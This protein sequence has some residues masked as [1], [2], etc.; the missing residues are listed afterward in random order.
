MLNF[1]IT[2]KNVNPQALEICKVLS[3]EGYQSFLVGGCVRDLLLGINPKDWDIC[4][5]ALPAKIMEIF[6]KNYPTGLKHGTITVVMGKDHFE[7]TTFRIEGEYKDGRRPEEVF[8]VTEIKQ[9]LSRRDLTI[10]AIS[11]DP[12]ENKLIDPFNGIDDLNNKIIRAVGNPEARFKEDGLRIM[13]TIRFAARLDYE[14]EAETLKAMKSCLNI[15][16]K[17]SLERIRDELCKILMSNNAAYGLS[18]LND[19]YVFCI[20]SP[21]IN[22]IRLINY[23]HLGELETRLAFLYHI[24]DVKL[25]R[26][27]LINLKFSNKEIKKVIFLLEL[28]EK[29]KYFADKDTP[30]SYKSF[31]ALLKNHSIDDFQETFNQFINLM[32]AAVGHEVRLLFD[33]YKD[34]IV[35]SKKEM[36]IDG[37]DLLE[38]GISAGPEIKRI[39]DL[40]YLEILRNPEHNE[41]E[42]LLKFTTT[43]K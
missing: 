1:K 20:V 17:V 12:L 24:Y 37:N 34:E 28:V 10:N 18:L 22:E 39:L 31:V 38:I 2:P 29:Y 36:N 30:L 21:L 26:Q 13:R 19:I 4:T 6:P 42:I 23:D 11:Y 32:D 43:I 7:I 5:D 15:L 40:C 9:D 27:E 8:F 25:V 33:K 14:I 41:K 16:R 3:R 35:F